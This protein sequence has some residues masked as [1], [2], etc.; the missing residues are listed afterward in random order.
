MKYIIVMRS[1]RTNSGWEELGGHGCDTS[2]VPLTDDEI[3][4]NMNAYCTALSN[5]VFKVV[6]AATFDNGGYLSDADYK[7]RIE[8]DRKRDTVKMDTTN[9]RRD[10]LKQVVALLETVK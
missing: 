1:K 6:E 9:M 4:S 5:D 7:K 2:D 10:A 3:L 8:E